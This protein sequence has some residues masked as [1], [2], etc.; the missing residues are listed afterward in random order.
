MKRRN[1]PLDL[2]CALT[3]IGSVVGVG[4][5][6]GA[7][8][9]AHERRPLIVHRVVWDAALDREGPKTQLFSAGLDGSD[10]R[11][12]YKGAKNW[13]LDL[14]LSRDGRWVALAPMRMS[15]RRAPL[16]VA[17]VLTG[18]HRNLLA[19]NRLIDH[20]GGIG[21]APD[22]R[23]LVFEGM[24]GAGP[25]RMTWLWT[26]RRDGSGLRRLPNSGQ[27]IDVNQVTIS[28]SLAWTP[29]GIFFRAPEGLM[30]V[31]D[32]RVRLVARGV[33]RL[34]IS[35]NGRWLFY[36][37][38]RRS[39]LISSLWRMHPDGTGQQRLI[40]RTR[41]HPRLGYLTSL[42]PDYS[43]RRLLT[44]ADGPNSHLPHPPLNIVHDSSRAPRLTDQRLGFTGGAY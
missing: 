2:L 22:G 11:P 44:V 18:E 37:R 14:T 30:R 9:G 35:G 21:W 43:G 31:R 15:L 33:F 25:R 3:C 5:P 34:R 27:P 24:Y 39:S 38:S 32:G 29:E 26:V 23:R 10:R 28:N 20:V 8:E 41:P 4:A 7:A 6:A 40:A 13:V 19:G 1:V 36:E 42:V 12:V 17:N 16:V